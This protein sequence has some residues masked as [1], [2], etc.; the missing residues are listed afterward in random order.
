VG[1]GGTDWVHLAQNRDRWQALETA[2]M[3]PQVPSNAGNFWT[4]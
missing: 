2:V 4:S 1:W 3:N